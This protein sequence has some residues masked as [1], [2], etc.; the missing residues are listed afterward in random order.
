MI[1]LHG[2][3]AQ[4]APLMAKAIQSEVSQAAQRASMHAALEPEDAAFSA[5]P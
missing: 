5:M 2:T 1:N 4:K 3:V